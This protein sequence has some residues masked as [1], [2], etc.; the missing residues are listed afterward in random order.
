[1]TVLANR[2]QCSINEA[3]NL[4]STQ[5]DYSKRLNSAF[6]EALQ[7][8]E[9]GM[10]IAFP[11]DIQVTL[12]NDHNFHAR[13]RQSDSLSIIEVSSQCIREIDVLWKQSWE[14]AILLDNQG[15]RTRDLDGS[16]L[17]LERLAHLSLSWLVL[18]E[19]MHV[20]LGHLEL[21]NVAALVETEPVTSEETS[22][23]NNLLKLLQEKLSTTEQKLIRPCLELQADNEA[24]E[25]MFGVYAE[26]EWGRF[27]I[28]AAAVFV[29][30]AL[31]EKAETKTVS[32]E[33]TYP[34]VASR[35]FTLFAQLFQYYLYEDAE[36]KT[37]DGESFVRSNS[38]NKD[39]KFSRY[40]KYV[41]AHIISDVV[42]I[43]MWAE[44]KTFLIDMGEGSALFRDI[45]EVQYAPDL[46]LANLQTAAAR[47]WRQ[48]MPINEIIME[49]SGLRN[50]KVEP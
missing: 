42:Q 22:S 18:H 41:L 21:L 27:R 31:M 43:A 34:K 5:V 9:Q 15:N 35:F 28:E 49:L 30:M 26:S 44:A 23:S 32:K 3:S 6:A 20:R 4:P 14:G 17:K 50:E 39:E 13:A 12:L 36:L 46:Q 38:S 8:Y 47:E 37:G 25:I 29:V 10:G 11:V 45:H 33:R 40:M 24:T 2:L 1:M 19:L 48:L 16:P 7:R